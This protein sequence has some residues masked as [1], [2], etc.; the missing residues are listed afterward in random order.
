MVSAIGTGEDRDM[1]DWFDQLKGII[2][3]H[4]PESDEHSLPRAAA[5]LLVELALTDEG[6]EKAEVE[7][8]HRAMREVFDLD[9]AEL[10]ELMAEARR[11]QADTVS[12]HGFTSQL[13]TGMEPKERAELV[14]WLWRVAFADGRLGRHEEHMVRRMADLLGIPHGEFIRRKHLAAD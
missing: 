13:R 14:E 5:V 6:G 9:Q 8:I 7:I 12:L 10:E 3:R 2:N 4:E 11:L 1:T